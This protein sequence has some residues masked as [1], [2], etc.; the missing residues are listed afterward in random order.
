[1]DMRSVIWRLLIWIAEIL[2][3]NLITVPDVDGYYPPTTDQTA[4]RHD[5]GIERT[6]PII[7]DLIAA[8][9]GEPP[10]FVQG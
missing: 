6:R 1:M 10:G 5:R 7:R 8:R 2:D 4:C 3:R 9:T